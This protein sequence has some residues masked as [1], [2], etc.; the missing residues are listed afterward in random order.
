MLRVETSHVGKATENTRSVG[1]PVGPWGPHTRIILNFAARSFAQDYVLT[2][3]S[4]LDPCYE[5]WE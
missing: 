5:I 3:G 4:I 1:D 2:E